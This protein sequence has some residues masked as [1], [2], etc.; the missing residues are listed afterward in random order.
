MRGVCVRGHRRL[1]ERV[2]RLG[3]RAVELT[4]PP[5]ARRHAVGVSVTTTSA[6]DKASVDA[7]AASSE[8]SHSLAR[9]G[10][11][12]CSTQSCAAS[13]GA[14]AVGTVPLGH[15]ALFLDGVSTR[16]PEDFRR[17]RHSKGS[18]GTGSMPRRS[19]HVGCLSNAAVKWVWPLA[20]PN[21]SKVTQARV[22]LKARRYISGSNAV[23]FVVDVLVRDHDSGDREPE[24]AQGLCGCEWP[25]RGRLDDVRRKGGQDL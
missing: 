10:V 2:A 25:V 17:R 9:C 21:A 5:S 14:S 20:A 15:A 16:G 22:T 12:R 7:E 24:A 18:P 11:L 13:R 8:P 4:P 23:R 1:P 6:R 3:R 19:A